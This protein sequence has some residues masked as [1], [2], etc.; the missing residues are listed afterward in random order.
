MLEFR[1]TE[2]NSFLFLPLGLQL[3]SG[4]SYYR[5]VATQFAGSRREQ[6]DNNPEAKPELRSDPPMTAN[7]DHQSEWI[8]AICAKLLSF[9]TVYSVILVLSKDCGSQ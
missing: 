8:K 9:Y 7:T 1:D 3:S 5:E 4:T 6:L 2:K